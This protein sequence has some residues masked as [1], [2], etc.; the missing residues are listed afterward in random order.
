MKEQ[1]QENNKN[2]KQEFNVYSKDEIKKFIKNKEN[3]YFVECDLGYAMIREKDIPDFIML[4]NELSIKTN[5]DFVD[6]EFYNSKRPDKLALS[7]YGILLNKAEPEL[8]DRIIGRL[9]KLQK[10]ETE[11]R[12]IKLID[13][14]LFIK[15]DEEV[16]L[17]HKRNEQKKLESKN[18]NKAKNKNRNKEAR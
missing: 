8:R 2:D 12:K 4:A 16:G 3:L 1:L 5:E 6:I 13:G 14:D 10:N 17:L 9:V 18:T 11:P 15:V 7:T